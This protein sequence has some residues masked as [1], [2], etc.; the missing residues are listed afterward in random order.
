[1][2]LV[3]KYLD[4]LIGRDWWV[5][6]D[7]FSAVFR[8]FPGRRLRRSPQDEGALTLAA[9]HVDLRLIWK[10]RVEQEDN[11]P[12]KLRVSLWTRSDV[13]EMTRRIAENA[14]QGIWSPGTL[15]WMMR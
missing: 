11:R 1:M 15:T 4:L 13:G 7:A 6:G 10:T 12:G 3:T 5:D 8:L 2:I 14:G 9:F